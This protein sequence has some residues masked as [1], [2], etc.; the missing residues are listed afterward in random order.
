MS[1]DHFFSEIPGKTNAFTD[2]AVS[3]MVT[4]SLIQC[5]CMGVSLITQFYKF[6]GN[7]PMMPMEDIQLAASELG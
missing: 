1:Q 4:S 7:V 6:M 2:I 3:E 5:N